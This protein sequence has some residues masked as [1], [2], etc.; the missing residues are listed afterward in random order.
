MRGIIS[1]SI[2]EALEEFGPLTI[3]E[4]ERAVGIPAP[5]INAAISEL[6]FVDRLVSSDGQRITL[7]A[8]PENW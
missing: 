7:E 5:H 8:P 4:L 1:K 2:L 6:C 3:P